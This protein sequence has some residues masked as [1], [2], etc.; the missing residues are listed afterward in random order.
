MVETISPV[1]HGTRTRW[2]AALGLHALGATATAAAF[3][4]AAGAIGALLGAP[5][6]RAG[7]LAILGAAVLYAA[8]ELFGLRVPVPQLRR[9]VPDWWRTYF[10]WA[11]ASF[12]YGAGLGIGFLT[13]LGH[14]TLVAVTVGVA[15]TG[16]PLLG[17][18]V[19]APFGLARGLAPLVA[20]RSGEPDDGRRLVDRLSAMGDGIRSALNAVALAG[21]AA[22]A[23]AA[24]WDTRG[25]WGEAAAAALAVAF[26]WAAVSK[27]VAA[28]RWRRTLAAHRLPS[29]VRRIAGWGVPMLEAL[30]PILVVLGRERAAAGVA[31]GSLLAFSLVLARAAVRGDLRVPCGCFGRP[32]VDV[33]AA[34]A[35]NAALAALAVVVWTGAHADPA[36]GLPAGVE[37]VP[38]G[39]VA[40]AI[41]VAVLTAWRAA[42][43]L[44]RGRA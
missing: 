40:G 44:G 9:Q 11:V 27:T 31:A 43:W 20:W 13:F 4:A 3:G 5:W 22:A 25:G 42:V 36:L 16:R 39:S 21:L 6:G 24:A 10:G 12:L 18:V 17:A 14:G 29:P 35:R 32:F 19:M 33:R 7:A 26:A 15:A 30:V 41:A 8:A 1:V 2:L 38:A 23:A 37:V 34:L 28:A